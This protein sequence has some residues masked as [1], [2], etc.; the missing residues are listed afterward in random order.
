MA[1]YP[2]SGIVAIRG[3]GLLGRLEPVDGD[4]TR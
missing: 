2:R 4:E 1:Y 3:L